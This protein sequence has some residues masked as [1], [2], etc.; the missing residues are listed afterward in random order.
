MLATESHAVKCTQHR[1]GRRRQ[2][3]PDSLASCVHESTTTLQVQLRLLVILLLILHLL[4]LTE[5]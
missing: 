2:L 1:Q 4:R 5:F 3:G